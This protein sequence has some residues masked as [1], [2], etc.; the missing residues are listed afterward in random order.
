[1]IDPGSGHDAVGSQMGLTG[2]NAVSSG[3]I[4]CVVFEGSCP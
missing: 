1:M 3:L 4:L 2:D